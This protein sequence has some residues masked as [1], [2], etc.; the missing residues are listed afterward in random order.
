M[1]KSRVN[2][3]SDVGVY[4]VKCKKRNN[5]LITFYL[6]LFCL[7][8]LLFNILLFTTM[9][10]I[11]LHVNNTPINTIFYEYLFNK[12]VDLKPNKHSFCSH[13]TVSIR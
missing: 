5:T 7:Q 4:R 2:F 10:T 13:K 11:V 1:N 3:I 9:L 8:Q 6:Q 12:R